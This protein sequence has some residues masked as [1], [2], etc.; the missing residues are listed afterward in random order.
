M[1]SQL[2]AYILI[3]LPGSGKSTW[4][5]K[6]KASNIDKNFTVISS[7]AILE[8]IAKEKGLTYSDVYKDYVGMASSMMKENFRKSLE[9]NRN[10]IWDQTNMS[11]KKR[12]GILSQ[13]DDRYKKVAVDFSVKPNLLKERLE[14]RAIQTGKVIPWKI[15]EDMGSSYNPPSKEEGFDEIIR[16]SY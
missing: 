16:I 10:I 13:L 1:D 7:D 2:Y 6:F 15:V 14:F 4:V 8:E 3:G 11:R 12:K 9:N 5:E